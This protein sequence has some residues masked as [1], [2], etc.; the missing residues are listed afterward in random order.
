MIYSYYILTLL[1]VWRRE[2]LAFAVLPRF[3]FAFLHF[4][5][6]GVKFLWISQHFKLKLHSKRLWGFIWIVQLNV[7][8]KRRLDVFYQYFTVGQQN[9]WFLL[10]WSSGNFNVLIIYFSSLF[11][12][13]CNIRSIH[14][15]MYF[16][17]FKI[18]FYLCFNL[19][20]YLFKWKILQM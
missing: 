7:Y 2:N 13:F 5:C 3:I 19:L 17:I 20:S 8:I 14:F 12:V 15:I 16:N 11:S 4:S 6:F 10:V 18:A 1:R 9:L